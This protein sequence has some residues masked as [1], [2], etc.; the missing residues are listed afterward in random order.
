MNSW[1]DYRFKDGSTLS[2]QGASDQNQAE[3]SIPEQD[4]SGQNA[5]GQDF[6]PGNDSTQTV[7]FTMRD[8]DPSPEASADTTDTLASSEYTGG[9]DNA[10]ESAGE[11]G[12]YGGGGSGTYSAAYGGD[13][14]YGPTG[15]GRSGRHSRKEKVP[16]QITRRGFV[17]VLI[18]CMII[19]S[20]L[21]MGG[22]YSLG[23][24]TGGNN[25]DATDYKL[26]K[27]TE[28]LSYTSIVSKAT[29][30]VVSITTESMATDNWMQNYVTEGAG[31]GIIIDSDGYI[32][33]CNH[34]IEGATKITVT[35]NDK[36]N[37]TATVVGTD[38]EHD[39]AVLKIKAKGLTA[40]TYGDSSELK[41]GDQVVAI[42]NPLGELSNTATTGI[43]SALNRNLTIDGK[44]MNL[45][46][47][48]ASINPGNSGG[49][50]FNAS[51]NL[52]GVVVAKSTGSDVEGLGFAIPIN[53]AAKIAKNLIENEGKNDNSNSSNALKDKVANGAVIGVTVT[54]LTDDEAAQYGYQ[55]GGVYITEVTSAKAQAAG[56]KSG[57]MI[58]S[59]DG[60]RISDY[61]TLK[62]QLSK[63]KAGDKVKI[64]VIRDN[65][66]YS[67]TVELSE[68]SSKS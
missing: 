28:T 12:S 60:T 37:Y 48:D 17:L 24:Y 40:A 36:K 62:N 49:A 56:L 25:K 64:T 10:Q 58:Y 65:K 20:A 5:A 2:D 63:H 44:T 41:V 43:I 26:T 45:L 50:L 27:S 23:I 42:G 30:S 61:S 15:G 59:F 46:Q 21:T 19:T 47:T 34:V 3:Q 7:N 35:L 4:Q 54:T 67:T 31:S 68:A 9:Y 38:S 16:M 11:Y 29:K 18:L 33:T 55:S 13:N 66:Q 57:D 8:P 1:D 53:R 14:Y 32:L 22:M 39:I 6:V 52:I 51:G